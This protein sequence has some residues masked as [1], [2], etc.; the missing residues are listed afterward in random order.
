MF[1]YILRAIGNKLHFPV[2]NFWEPETRSI[3]TSFKPTDDHSF[4][5][6]ENGIIGISMCIFA[7]HFSGVFYENYEI[8]TME[9]GKREGRELIE[10]IYSKWIVSG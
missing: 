5:K 4:L 1:F 3:K 2:V 8:A 6:V 10:L 7:Y 9:M